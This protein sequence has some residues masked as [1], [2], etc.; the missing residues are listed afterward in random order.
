VSQSPHLA[1]HRCVL[2]EAGPTRGHGRPLASRT[3]GSSRCT[4]GFDERPGPGG[5]SATSV[6]ARKRNTGSCGCVSHRSVL[7]L[8]SWLDVMENGRRCASCRRPILTYDRGSTSGVAPSSTRPVRE[9]VL[10][11]PWLRG[12]SEIEETRWKPGTRFVPDATFEATCRTCSVSAN[13]LIVHSIRSS[14]PIVGPSPS[15]ST[16]DT[17]E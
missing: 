16:A 10:T 6:A 14:S 17:G 4:D 9:I 12:E 15:S 1:G 11:Q 3:A 2:H 7:L 13:P 5:D 8:V